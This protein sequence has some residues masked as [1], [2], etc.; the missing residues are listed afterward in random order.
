MSVP[1]GLVTP[2]SQRKSQMS[3]WMKRGLIAY[4]SALIIISLYIVVYIWPEQN[5]INSFQTSN[6][7]KYA[8]DK[9]QINFISKNQT[10]ERIHNKTVLMFPNK[11]I[12]EIIDNQSVAPSF[13]Q[14]F[15]NPSESLISSQAVRLI[16]LSILFG[17]LGASVHGVTSLSAWMGTHKDDRGWNMWYLVRP[18]VGAGL[19]VITYLIIRAG[20]VQGAGINDFGVAAVSALVGLMTVPMTNKLRDIFDSLFG[21]TKP[22]VDKGEH[23][24]TIYKAQIKV[25]PQKTELK[26]NERIAIMAMVTTNDGTPAEKIDVVF[27]LSNTDVMK[28]EPLHQTTTSK[29]IATT[30]ATGTNKGETTVT[31]TATVEETRYEKIEQTHISD[32]QTIKVIEG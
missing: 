23:S 21:I 20:L 15:K 24:A 5:I 7:T 10:I 25:H 31:A 22:N 2:P 18:P 13:V 28:I 4:F 6:H 12:S 19:A 1:T 26:I 27:S 14:V 17:I 16:V 8:K 9:I 3:D 30:I 29:G 11:T 32:K